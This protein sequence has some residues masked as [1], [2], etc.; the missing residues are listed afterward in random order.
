VVLLRKQEDYIR[1]MQE[2]DRKHCL[3][4]SHQSDVIQSSKALM[5]MC[6]PIFEVMG[7][8][9]PVIFEEIRK[10]M[11]YVDEGEELLSGESQETLE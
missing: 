5:E 1:A 7:K 3:I 8:C 4:I 2:E 10:C 6:L 11:H 9:S